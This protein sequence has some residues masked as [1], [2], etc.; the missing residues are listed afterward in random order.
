MTY[1]LLIAGACSIIFSRLK[2]PP[3]IG[4]LAAGI[5][6]GPTILGDISVEEGTITLLSNLGIVMLMFSIGLNLNL[7]KLRQLGSYIIILLSLE[8]PLMVVAGYLTGLA[9]GLDSVGAI[10]LGAV[11]SGTSTA[12]VVAVLHERK[13]EVSD[14]VSS[15]TTSITVMEDLG[16]VLILSLAAPCWWATPLLW[17]SL[18]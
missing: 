13:D 10:F 2:L 6:I 11:I 12:V 4:Y 5:I 1:L 17:A 7:N 3:I 14:D 9:I 18:S 8:M 15:T 16:Q